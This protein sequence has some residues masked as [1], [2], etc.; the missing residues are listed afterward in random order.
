MGW[1]RRVATGAFLLHHRG[2]KPTAPF[3]SALRASSN[4]HLT[5]SSPGFL[6]SCFYFVFS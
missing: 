3:G 1:G 2:L 5:L 4:Q 6:A